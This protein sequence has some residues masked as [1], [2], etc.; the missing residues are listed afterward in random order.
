MDSDSL[1]Y[2]WNQ[3]WWGL[4][5]KE[6]LIK[7]FKFYG[8]T[9]NDEA[10]VLNYYND[11]V[12]QKN[13]LIKSANCDTT[14]FARLK[15]AFEYL[16]LNGIIAVHC[17][18]STMS[19]GIGTAES[20]ADDIFREVYEDNLAFDTAKIMGYCFYHE[21]DIEPFVPN[22]AATTVP[23]S[24]FCLAFGALQ[25]KTKSNLSRIAETIIAALRAQDLICDWNGS[26]DT[27][28]ILKDF[29]WIKEAD[30]ICWENE[31]INIFLRDYRKKVV[32]VPQVF[33][34]GQKILL[35]KGAFKGFWGIVLGIDEAES[36]LMLELEVFGRKTPIRVA[37][38]Q[39]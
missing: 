35:S 19:A 7:C 37:F 33:E 26:F 2:M 9:R 24:D 39:I 30:D 8:G 22:L 28:I 1:A 11:F 17:A 25:D 6:E 15:A 5:P 20:I 27:R 12:A 14:H 16:N 13:E 36:S 18:G 4:S 34:I 38:H 23:K 21:Q 31:A 32:K 29:I 10:S 3:V